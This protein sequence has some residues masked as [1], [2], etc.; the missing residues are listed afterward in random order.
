MDGQEKITTGYFF[1]IIQT[2]NIINFTFKAKY[3]SSNNFSKSLSHCQQTPISLTY[4]KM[5]PQVPH[6]YEFNIYAHISSNVYIAPF[7][8]I[9]ANA[10]RSNIISSVIS[11]AHEKCCALTKYFSLSM[12]INSTVTRSYTLKWYQFSVYTSW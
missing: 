7:D 8:N 5:M 2:S 11:T 3:H 10:V 12:T 4:G 6:A 9:T 1:V